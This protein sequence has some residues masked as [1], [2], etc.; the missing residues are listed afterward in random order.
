MS[1]TWADYDRDG[2]MD[3][4]LSERCFRA[5]GTRSVPRADFNPSMP[6]RDTAKYLK[7]VR[8]NTLLQ[9]HRTGPLFGCHPIPWLKALPAGLGAPS[10][11]TSTMTAGKDLY[12]ANGYISQ[13]DK[14]DL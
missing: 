3:L 2:H 12:V 6:E 9:K 13:P 10:S 14:D 5:P 11:L 1:A 7:M 8:G 4:Y